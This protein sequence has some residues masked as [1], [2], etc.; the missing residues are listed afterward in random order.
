MINRKLKKYIKENIFLEYNKNDSSHNLE[1][2]KYVIRR[3]LKFAKEVSGINLDMVYVIAAYH[4]IVHHIDSKNHERISLEMLMNDKNLRKFFNEE[5]IRI[6]SEA[7][8][9]RRASSEIE[10]PRSVY[11]E[12]I[13]TVDRN[14]NIDIV[15]IR[16]FFAVKERQ[17]ETVIEDYLDYTIDRLRK[18]Y[19]EEKPE[20]I[21]YENQ[22]NKEFI[23][24]MIDLLN[25][26]DYFKER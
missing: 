2:I 15:F 10:R 22:T 26:E 12:I 14:T 17:P 21:F 8:E 4:D 16:S 9:D 23:K 19:D 18:K 25:R 24:D 7:V 13:S 5:Q 3:S 11:G 6:M 1:Y 20:N